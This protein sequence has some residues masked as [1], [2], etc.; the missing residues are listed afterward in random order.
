MEIKELLAKYIAGYDLIENQLSLMPPEVMHFKPAPNK[1]SISEVIVH[2]AD[3]ESHGFVR[4]KKIIAESGGG[5]TVYN[6]QIW[7][8]NLFYDKMNH[9]DALD[10]IR[11]L[12]KNLYQVLKLLPEKSWHNYIFHPESGKITLIDWIQLYIDHINIHI[13]QMHR[14]F[15]DWQKAKEKEFV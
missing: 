1:W 11:I 10:M 8:D 4:A 12:R 5:V 2:L 13:Q 14:N 9:K 3:S 6:Q 15:Y 7:A